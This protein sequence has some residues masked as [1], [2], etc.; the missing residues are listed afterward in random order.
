MIFNIWLNLNNVYL[1]SVAMYQITTD[2]NMFVILWF[3][4]DRE[5]RYKLAGFSVKGFHR[6]QS[7]VSAWTMVLSELKILFLAHVVAG[8]IQV[9]G[10]VGLR[11]LFS[12]CL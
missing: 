10:I 2:Y 3:P 6:L 9:L 8:R 4:W 12:W 5:L 1:F 11:Y 7:K